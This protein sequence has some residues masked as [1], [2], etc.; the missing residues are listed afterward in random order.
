MRKITKCK[1]QCQS[2]TWK[3]TL[4]TWCA[5][6]HKG[7]LVLA[8][9]FLSTITIFGKQW[10]T[11]FLEG[12]YLAEVSDRWSQDVSPR[13]PLG[14]QAPWIVQWV[15]QTIFMGILQPFL[16]G[17]LAT[18]HAWR[19]LFFKHMCK[20]PELLNLSNGNLPQIPGKAVRAAK[21]HRCKMIP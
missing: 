3:Q 21:N 17:D 5:K 10:F 16:G 13:V 7:G 2:T 1:I 9:D 6:A 14:T 20:T 12:F 18:F 19:F 15:S 8:L 4:N 11:W